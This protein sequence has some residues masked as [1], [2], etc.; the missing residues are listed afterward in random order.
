[1]KKVLLVGNGAREHVIAETLHHGAQI[2]CYADAINPGIR[3]LSTAYTVGKLS[4]ISALVDFARVQKPDFAVIGPENPICLGAADRLLEI[5]VPCIAPFREAARLESS[6][7]FTR[8]L[9]EKYKIPGNP[10]FHIFETVKGIDAFMHELHG[11]CVI[12]ADGLAGGKGVKVA[13]DHFQTLDEGLKYAFECIEKHGRVVIEEKLVGQEFSLMSFVDGRH[14]VSMPAVQ[15]HKRA[16][17]DDR[18]PN[19]GGMGSYSDANHG[20]PFL[21]EQDVQEAEL[22]NQATVQALHSETGFAFK[23]ILYGGFMATRDGVKL[24]EFNVRFGDP[25]AMN[26]LPILETNFVTICEAIIHGHLDRLSVNFQKKATVT[27][28]VVPEGYP[29]NPQKGAS[30]ELKPCPKG[31]KRYFASVNEKDGKF[32]LGGSRTVAFVG[33]ADTLEEAEQLAE[34]GTLTVRGHVFHRRDVGTSA[35]IAQRVAMM[36]KLRYC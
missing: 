16:Y 10:L 13:S 17:D 22:I 24:I 12:K 5:N 33:I 1:M 27:K 35:L 19:T 29:D 20:L 9:L 8:E 11:N 26:V 25:E 32:F 3:D 21:T 23:G 28:Y 36:R 14:L 6:K 15:D 31:V 4:D 2:F 34:E 30:I 7:S 18:G